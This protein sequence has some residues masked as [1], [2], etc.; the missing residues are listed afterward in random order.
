MSCPG[1][2][3]TPKLLL[4]A[5]AAGVVLAMGIVINSWFIDSPSR[6]KRLAQAA[7]IPRPAVIAHRGASYLAPEETRAAYLM[8]GELGAD[9]LEFDVQRTRDGVLIALHDETIARTSNVARVFPGREK[10]TVDTF[11]FAELRQLDFGEWFNRRYPDRA[12]KKFQGLHI[13]QLEEILDIAESAPNRPGVYIEMKLSQ[14]FPGIEDQLLE[15]LR[16][17]GWTGHPG[18]AGRSPVVFQS[19]EPESL[20][21]LKQLAPEVPRLLLVDEVLVRK[22]GWE[23]VLQ[24]SAATAMG[25]GTWGYAWA[26]GPDWSRSEMFRYVATWP[27]YTSQAHKAGLFVQPWTIDDPWEMRMVTLGGADGIFTNRCD[28][29]LRIYGRAP[30]SDIESLWR[31]IGY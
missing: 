26:S 22:L 27:W 13:L 21:R 11:T 31:K 16:K 12:R 7:G 25:M 5:L 20:E 29:A 24:T 9:Y 10:D 15:V 28:V 6:G 14:R 30:E 4:A 8:A 17:R 2:S 23:G 1:V 19:F 18:V 3:R